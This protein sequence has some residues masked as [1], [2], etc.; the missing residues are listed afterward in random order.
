MMCRN[1]SVFSA[2]L[3]FLMC[4]CIL[5]PLLS[6]MPSGKKMM[7]YITCG[8]VWRPGEP[9]RDI[10]TICHTHECDKSLLSSSGLIRHLWHHL[11]KVNKTIPSLLLWHT[12]NNTH[13]API[14]VLIPGWLQTSA[15]PTGWDV[16]TWPSSES[17]LIRDKNLWTTK[18]WW[19]FTSV[20]EN[21]TRSSQ[22]LRI[23]SLRTWFVRKCKSWDLQ[24]TSFYFTFNKN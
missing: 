22:S 8:C 17:N 4:C 23:T 1:V 21:T 18:E 19:G 11:P 24:Q 12:G 5:N 14:F 6:V 20:F 9:R 16:Q 2:F 7:K 13:E 15:M 10:I 3:L